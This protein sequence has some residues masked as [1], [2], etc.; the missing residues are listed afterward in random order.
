M[1]LGR[2]RWSYQRCAAAE[3]LLHNVHMSWPHVH[4]Y[5]SICEGTSVLLLLGPTLTA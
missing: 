2:Q 5:L 1:V 3:M 4:V